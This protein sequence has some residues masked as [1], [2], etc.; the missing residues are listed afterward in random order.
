MLYGKYF[1]FY[2]LS[3]LFFFKSTAVYGLVD[4]ITGTFVVGAFVTG[5]FYN[6]SNF[7]MPNI[8]PIFGR[9][10]KTYNI[11]ELESAIEK[12]FFGQHIATKIVLSALAGNL[13]RSKS[14]KKPLVM[15]FQG[16]TGSGKNF[17]TEL[18]AS[19]MFTSEAVRKLRFHVIHGRSDF[20][21]QSQINVYK[22]KLYYDVKSTIKSCDTNV[23]VFDE[24]H[25]IPMG[26]LDI[27]IPIL[28]NNDVSV[29]S[30]NSIFIFLT[31]AGG[32]AI[33]TKYLD[34]WSKGISRESMRIQDFDT[35]LQKSAFNEKGGL[36]KSGLIDSHIVDYYVPF[37]PLERDHVVKCIEAEFKNLKKYLDSSTKSEILEMVSFGPE[38]ENLFA[39]SGCKRINQFVASQSNSDLV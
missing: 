27:L 31:N 4:P 9:C 1:S 2:I 39:T 6:K 25:Y 36:M 22:E 34:L 19:H 33:V 23:F 24:T 37:L 13:Q 20:I 14:N 11:K 3:C 7:T 8:F 26:I 10:P 15:C 28:E 38:P 5:Y 35:I 29:D 32:K 16:W 30:R 18:I 17:L 21:Y 12:S